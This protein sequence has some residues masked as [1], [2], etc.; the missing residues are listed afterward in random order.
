MKVKIDMRFRGRMM[1]RQ[2]VGRQ[3]MNEFLEKVSD[4]AN[5]EKRPSLEGNVMSTVL[6][7]KKK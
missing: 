5:V 7:P 4:L 1:T 2:D 3:I 6:A